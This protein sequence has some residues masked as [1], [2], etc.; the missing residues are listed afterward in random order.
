[1]KVK[2]RV[3]GIIIKDKKVLLVKGRGFTELWTPGGTIEPKESDEQT[4]ARELSEELGIK[5]LESSFF[6]GFSMPSPYHKGLIATT[7]LY[8][9]KISGELRPSAEIESYVWYSRSDHD[10]RKYPMIEAN[11]LVVIPKLIELG[12]I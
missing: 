2:V 4:L 10:S 1:M 7:K 11:D 12:L 9:A 6:L 3:A 5:L 8:L